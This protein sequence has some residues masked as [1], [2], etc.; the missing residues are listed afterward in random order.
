MTFIFK[1]I[2]HSSQMKL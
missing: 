1:L 2:D